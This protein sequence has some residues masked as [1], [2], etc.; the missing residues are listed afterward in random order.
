VPYTSFVDVLL[1][2]VRDEHVL[3]ALREGTGYADGQWN[4]PSGKLDEGEDVQAA[5]LRETHEEIGLH[6]RRDWVRMAAAL[7]YRNPEGRARVGF[8]FHAHTW[9]G[10]PYN[11]EPH[12][13]A[14]IDWFP[15]DRLPTNTVPY[16]RAGIDLFRRDEPFGLAGWPTA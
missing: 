14:R 1:L 6:L 11:A 2:L 12:K 9:H 10:E 13:C 8:F 5:M 16:T 15:L 3:L 7:H 4:L